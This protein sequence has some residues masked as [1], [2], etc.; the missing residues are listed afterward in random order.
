MRIG[1]KDV[2]WREGPYFADD[3]ELLVIDVNVPADAFVS[4][5]QIDALADLAIQ[6]ALYDGDF[7]VD[8]LRPEAARIVWS[9]GPDAAPTIL[10]REDAT[11]EAP[12]GVFG[13][14]DPFPTDGE[15][16]TGNTPADMVT[17]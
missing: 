4:D 6:V 5:A 3:L 11:A 14:V 12:L 15:D 16:S 8:A 9:G 1:D 17:R 13:V 10:D 7:R 2:E